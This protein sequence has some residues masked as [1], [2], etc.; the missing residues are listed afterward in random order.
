M[1]RL[2][3]YLLLL[4][5]SLGAPLHA[6][7]EEDAGGP[8]VRLLERTLSNDS[9]TIRVTGLE[10]ALSSRATIKQIEVSDENG[11]WLRMTGAVLDWNRV[12]LVR[13]RFSV[14]E[15]T[16]ESIEMPRRPVPTEDIDLPAPEAQPFQMPELPVSIEIAKMAVT[17]VSLG[18]PV[19]GA[20]AR[21]A[22]DGR[23]S[24]AD[25]T[26]DTDLSIDR[27]DG[28]GD[29]VAII[30]GFANDT[31][32]INLDIQVTEDAG[33]LV[34]RL[35]NMPGTPTLDLSV[36]GAG[37]V[38]DFI[39]K[40]KL[41]TD[42]VDRVRGQVALSGVG[43]A[44]GPNQTIGFSGQV[45]GD[46]R[47]LM[48]EDF[49]A[50]FGPRSEI[51][52]VG[53]RM[54][55][56]Q[57]DVSSLQ[58]GTDAVNLTG[59]L[60]LTSQSEV[61]RL[62][63]DLALE[64]AE[65][66]PI[67]LPVS[68][69]TTRV[70]AV[71]AKARF[72]AAQGP[73]WALSA[74]LDGFA[75]PDLG[76][77]NAKLDASGSYQPDQAAPLSGTI[78]AQLRGLRFSDA[79][80]S[81]AVGRD[82]NLAGDFVL[83]QGDNLRLNK[84]TLE[85]S[86]VQAALTAAITG[87]RKGFEVTGEVGLNIAD[88]S[89]FEALA[90][91]PIAGALSAQLSGKAAPIGGTFD[92]QLTATAQDLQAG[93][94]M[95]DQLLIGQT[96]LTLDAVRGPDGLQIRNLDLNGTALTLSAKGQAKTGRADLDVVAQLDDLARLRP[97]L[98]GPVTIT[99][100][101]SQRR[102]TWTLDWNVDA[103]G[104]AQA[105]VTATLPQD[106]GDGLAFDLEI[107]E[108]A[109]GPIGQLLSLPAN[110]PLAVTAKGNGALT[111]FTADLS[112]ATQGQPRL[113][114]TVQIREQDS[115]QPGTGF[116]AAFSGDFTPFLQ[117]QYHSFFG[118]SS[119]LTANGIRLQDGQ[120]EL[121]KLNLQTNALQLTGD[122]RINAQ[123]QPEHAA[124]TGTL[125]TAAGPVQLPIP[126]APVTLRHAQIDAALDA[127][128]DPGWT[129]TATVEGLSHSAGQLG[130]MTLRGSGDFDIG[131]ALSADG[132]LRAGLLGLSLSDPAL[133]AALGN[134]LTLTTGFDMVV[135]ETLALTDTLLRGPGLEANVALNLT[136][137]SGQQ[138]ITSNADLNVRDFARFSDLAQ[139]PLTG[140]GT[141]TASAA[142]KLAPRELDVIVSSTL[143]DLTTGIP[144]ADAIMAGTYRLRADAQT[145]ADGIDL[146]GLRFAG[147]ALEATVSGFVSPTNPDIQARI[148]LNDLA[149][150]MPAL[151]GEVSIDAGLRG[152]AGRYIADVN[153]DAP[154]DSFVNAQASHSPDGVSEIAFDG[155]MNK[156][157]RFMPQFPGRLTGKGTLRRENE[158]WTIDADATGP[159]GIDVVTQGTYSE[160][161]GTVDASA[162]GGLQLAAA[163]VFISPNSVEGTGRFDVSITGKP[164]L[165]SLRGQINLTDVSAAFPRLQNSIR[166]A[167]GT[168]SLN[169]AGAAVAMQGELSTGG[170]FSINGPVGM[171][172]PYPANL[173]INLNQLIMTDQV[174]YRAPVSGQLQFSGPVTGN[175][176]LAGR[177]DIGE[178]DINVGNIGGSSSAAPIPP[179]TH[180][181]E[182]GPVRTTRAR[183][184]LLDSGRSGGPSAPIDL[185]LLISA[186]HKI[187]VRGRGLNA[188]LGGEIYVRGNTNRIAPAGQIELLRGI[189]GL[190]GRRLELSRGLITLQG[191]LQP[192][193]E[194]AATSS[195]NS[196]TAT[197]EMS[198]ELDAIDISITSDPELPEEEA[199]ALLIFGNEFSSLS[200]FKIAQIATG[201]IALRGGGD[202]VDTQGR[203]ATGA[204]SVSLANDTGGLPSLE[205]GG[206][207]S[208]NIYT[209]V[210]V[211]TDGDTELNINLDVTDNL[212]L[213]GMV[214]NTGESGIGIFF[215]R[216]Y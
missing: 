142:G 12:A 45:D 95:L 3:S 96:D 155:Q 28:P 185:D 169:D 165:E 214:D 42:G 24:L 86:H 136:D 56:G 154:N 72:D 9:R 1:K 201:L 25:G 193:L 146:R 59:S 129:L 160:A 79:A 109:G 47:P 33:G 205:L 32:Q 55:N 101:T 17:E 82:A 62:N 40:L 164:A 88:L 215:D 170:T 125:G 124:L 202:V 163:N 151:P 212:T 135:G 54:A 174:V 133:G 67:T 60:A 123:G 145:K 73:G 189:M 64:Q 162:T 119:E 20:A 197:L 152:E 173:S 179:L 141:V 2:A 128:T 113:T 181:R 65:G 143:Q 107:S 166:N 35:L 29:K 104:G 190:F 178:T 175:S 49:H 10:G 76:L 114:G 51:N 53:Q 39:A 156:L 194:F 99:G 120:M 140:S 176:R 22:L 70:R 6:Q 127:G 121:S 184:G 149:L 203:K 167:G 13:G 196:G 191:S 171:Q 216:E 161:D 63:L 188:E 147:D 7:E 177:I 27:L 126:G 116:E 106:L 192:Y 5:I 85:A 186:P 134:S 148:L 44:E 97:D 118:S 110:P 182:P 90:G 150:V 209:D 115:P 37:P 102:E 92:L 93:Q 36:Q 74:Q 108:P 91:R 14:N 52:L 21:L 31:R 77:G 69:G 213:K 30:A 168:I 195:T 48:A 61:A 71:T 8:L 23:V 157:E 4:V 144:Q 122:A 117:D 18:E 100:T 43:D 46:L 19:A 130:Q 211:N 78:N 208:D 58:L 112:L 94:D 15:L 98:P 105:A 34:S 84:M 200:P 153:I 81:K 26:L 158:V 38:H 103:P 89:Q 198:G 75:Q 139:R 138:Q 180:V 57:L 137:L 16:A 111:D 172:A 210:T 187:F 83:S 204:N 132:Q 50:F 206:Y 41:A 80:L 11:V 66:G 131:A 207:L 183:A 159:A 68:G 199:L 87:L